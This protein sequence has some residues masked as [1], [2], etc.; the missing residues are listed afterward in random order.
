M[1]ELVGSGYRATVILGGAPSG[2]AEENADVH[3]RVNDGRSYNGVLATPGNLRY[4]LQ[5]FAAEG[6]CASGSYVWIEGLL[7]VRD[8]RLETM[9]AA[10]DG[11]VA[12]GEIGA[13]FTASE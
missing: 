12:S 7:V 3:V 9:I 4:L 13:A 10:L 11:L 5:K 2:P 1:I 8:F 6:D